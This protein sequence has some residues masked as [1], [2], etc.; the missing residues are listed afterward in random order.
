[1]KKLALAI[2][3]GLGVM[4]TATHVKAHGVHTHGKDCK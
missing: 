3:L 4:V 1:M 2:M